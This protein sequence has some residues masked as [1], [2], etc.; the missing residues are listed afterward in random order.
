MALEHELADCLWSVLILA[1]RFDVD[2][3]TA[4]RRTMTELEAAINIRLAGDEDPS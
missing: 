3:E 2:L 1:R 4:F